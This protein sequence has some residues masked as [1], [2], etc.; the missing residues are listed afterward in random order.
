M[1]VAKTTGCLKRTRN[2][3]NEVTIPVSGTRRYDL[4]GY[5]NTYLVFE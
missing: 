2:T 1:I 5:I 4:V 3:K